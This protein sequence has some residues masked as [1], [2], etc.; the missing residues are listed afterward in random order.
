MA[1]Y[2]GVTRTNEY[3]MHYG[4]RGMKW[5]V[6]RAL[7]N[8]DAKKLKKHHDK[9]VEKLYRLHEKANLLTKRVDSKGGRV[10]AGLGTGLA[11]AGTAANALTA[12]SLKKYGYALVSPAAAVAAPIGG[13]ALAGLG[14]GQA[15]AARYRSG[16]KGHARAV[17]KINNWQ[18]EMRKTFKGTKFEQE[19]SERHPYKDVYSVSDY[20]TGKQRTTAKISGEKLT[21]GYK[22]SD[23][24]RFI[25][26]ASREH[27]MMAAP[28]TYDKSPSNG[29][30]T[31][32]SEYLYGVYKQPS[33]KKRRR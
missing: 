9:A 1:Q 17:Q 25:R 2:Y 6:R 5:G 4:V 28:R 7:K 8:N 3:L 32:V 10:L 13:A 33:G 12:Q 29:Q 14:A 16:A 30:E 23:R 15:I 21:R 11:A 20:S 19:E 24:D 27:R 18:N 22:G 31:H 26:E